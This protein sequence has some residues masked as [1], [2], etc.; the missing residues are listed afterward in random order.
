[1]TDR[2]TSRIDEW[3]KEQIDGAAAVSL[4]DLARKGRDVFLADTAYLQSLFADQLQSLIHQRAAKIF[5]RTRRGSVVLGDE[6]VDAG[7]LAKRAERLASKW[8]GWLEHAGERHVLLF[9][10]TRLQLV[11]AAEER[12]ARSE[13]EAIR[14]LFLRALAAKLGGVQTVGEVFDHGAIEA[15]WI[16]AHRAF[17]A[18][19][20][21]P[22][23]SA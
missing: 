3:I 6:I 14:A 15:A 4:T 2:A 5:E 10:M 18:A 19:A 17:Q 11:A 16:A 12:E 9:S 7:E 1:M 21:R 23:R 13:G 8:D 22:V 20:S